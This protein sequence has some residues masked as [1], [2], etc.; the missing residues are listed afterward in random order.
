MTKYGNEVKARIFTL[1]QSRLTSKSIQSRLILYRS[2]FQLNKLTCINLWSNFRQVEWDY[3]WNFG[4]KTEIL[5]SILYQSRNQYNKCNSIW[6][7]GIFNK[8]Y[9]NNI[10][11]QNASIKSMWMQ[12]GKKQSIVITEHDNKV[13]FGLVQALAF[14]KNLCNMFCLTF[15]TYYYQQFRRRTFTAHTAYFWKNWYI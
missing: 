3:I 10:L 14:S 9:G 12:K 2:W 5:H 7:I 8:V 1:K 15:I 11:V 4:T 13:P 6:K